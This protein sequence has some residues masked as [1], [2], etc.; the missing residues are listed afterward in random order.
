MACGAGWAWLRAP[1]GVVHLADTRGP[2]GPL[3]TIVD[4]VPILAP[5]DGVSID[6]SGARLWTTPPAPRLGDPDAVRAT[7]EVVRPH[8]W[9]DPRAFR[10]GHEPFAALASDLVERGPGLTPAGA[11]AVTGYIYALRA[12]TS[13]P[14]HADELP[15]PQSE[16]ARSLLRAADAGEAFDAVAVMLHT[17]VRGDG[18]ALPAAVRR[19]TRLGRTTGRAY[20]TGMVCALTRPGGPAE[21]AE[22]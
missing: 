18:P 3:T 21:R 11:D 10:L 20:L 16:P 6:L 9:N 19:L 17:L 14:T 15:V 1:S 4:T 22:S 7:C 2:R 5:G 12:L 8:V 13:A